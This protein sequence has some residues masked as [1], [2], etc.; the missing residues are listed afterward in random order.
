MLIANS[1]MRSVVSLQ[2]SFVVIIMSL[3]GVIIWHK[4]SPV[5]MTSRLKPLSRLCPHPWPHGPVSGPSVATCLYSGHT[6][7]VSRLVHD[8]IA[9]LCC[10]LDSGYCSSVCLKLNLL[11]LCCPCYLALEFLKTTDLTVP[12]TQPPRPHL[13]GT[14][15]FSP[16][17]A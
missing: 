1:S 16:N 9:P 11:S 15:D 8:L 2:R 5:F 13:W 3:K 6:S 12:S 17:Q 4:T 10:S 7:C 14:C